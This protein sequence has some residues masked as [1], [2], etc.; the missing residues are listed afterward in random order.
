MCIHLKASAVP[1]SIIAHSSKETCDGAISSNNGAV[2]Q[3][4]SCLAN[5]YYDPLVYIRAI[6]GC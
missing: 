4:E 3:D 1:G 2:F 6:V 5:G